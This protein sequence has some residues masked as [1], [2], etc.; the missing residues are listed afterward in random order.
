MLPTLPPGFTLLQVTPRLGGGGVERATVDMAGAVVEA[1]YRSIIA[2]HGG[3]E[4]DGEVV[5]LPVHSRNPAVMLANVGRL[6]KLIRDHFVSVVHVR[7][8]APAFSAIAAAR[9]VGVPV[10]ATYHGI[11][12][13]GSPLKRWYNGVMT[14]GDLVIANSDFT[15]EHILSQHR[16]APDRIVVVPEGIDT[17][18]FDPAVVSLER[19][20]SVRA[21][22]GLAPD[23]R[24]RILL[25]AARLTS[26]KGQGTAILALAARSRR[27]NA[28][29]I[30]AGRKDSATYAAALG[31][32]AAK[33]GVAGSVVF[34]GPIADMPAALLT[35]DVVVAPST[36]AES[37]GRV[38]VEAAAMGRPIV[39]SAIGAHLETVEDGVT[40]WLVSPAD[41]AAWARA[42]D[43]AL[44]MPPNAETSRE[45]AVRL[46]SLG[47]MV[48][49]TFEVYRR[50]LEGPR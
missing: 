47:A 26:W 14:R 3:G 44:A 15:R 46:Y 13:A 2:A 43:G 31:D 7:S 30:L 21:A 28:V 42:I 50:L 6:A 41:P 32:L 37:F 45:R 22:W 4:A 16:V 27:E 36:K 19:I 35:A 29:L 1:G 17:A 11:Y 23:D 39:A 5:D 12:S 24:R 18:R 10:V 33:S 20:A 25:C 49:G 38:V 34:A 40:G 8:R 48:E 9:R